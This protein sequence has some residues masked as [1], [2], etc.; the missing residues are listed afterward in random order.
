[1]KLSLFTAALSFASAFVPAVYAA[2][3]DEVVESLQRA[4]KAT[5]DDIGYYKEITPENSWKTGSVSAAAR[6]LFTSSHAPSYSRWRSTGS[7]PL[8]R[9]LRRPRSSL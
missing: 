9:E 1:M 3:K 5:N 6:S 4:I 7:K 2:T 8:S